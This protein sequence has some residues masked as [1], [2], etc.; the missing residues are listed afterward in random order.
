MRGSIVKRELK[1]EGTA[2]YIVLEIG[3]DPKTGKRKQQWI[4]VKGTKRDA[5][6]KL[7]D[8]LYQ[9]DIGEFVKPTKITVSEYLQS[10]L[11]DYGRAK[12]SP[13]SLER[14]AGI[15]QKYFLPEF[16]NVRLVQLRPEHLQDHYTAML[17]KGL[18]ART[19]RYHQAVIH[20]ALETAVKRKLLGRNVAD[21]VDLPRVRHREMNAW[22]GSEAGYFLKVAKDTPYYALFFT[23]L[24]TGMRRSELLGLKWQ[25]ID[26]VY[27]RISIKRG[28]HHLKSGK[29]IF[30]ELKSET[31]RRKI[32]LPPPLNLILKEYREKQRLERMMSG[33]PLTDNDLVFST[34]EGEPLRPN[35]ITRA[36]QNLAKKCGLKMIRFHDARHTFATLML[37]FGVHPKVVSLGLGHAGIQIT[38]DTYSH[39]D[40]LQEAAAKTYG[41]MMRQYIEIPL[42]SG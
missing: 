4:T 5:E 3:K 40:R 41:E 33:Q 29:Y 14:Y 19:I 13:R 7:R 24:Y 6:R 8:L 18:S 23:A 21:A 35:T 30:T 15:V 2:Y 39:L 10:W 37:E 22:T 1:N 25:D 27:S 20:K 16:G 9:L 38:L 17:D 32:G 11:D 36:W 31:S 42:D 34:P 28:L 12:L 26:F